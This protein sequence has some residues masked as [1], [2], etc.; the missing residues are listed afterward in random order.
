MLVNAACFEND[1]LY[2]FEDCR[3]IVST[4]ALDPEDLKANA[5]SLGEYGESYLREL[6]EREQLRKR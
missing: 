6:R 4:Y 5:G 3:R 1:A 2:F